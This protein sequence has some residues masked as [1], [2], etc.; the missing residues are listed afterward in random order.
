[1]KILVPIAASAALIFSAPAAAQLKCISLPHA[2]QANEGAD[3]GAKFS[4]ALRQTKACADLQAYELASTTA[5][6]PEEISASVVDRC[7]PHVR[8]QSEY[9][10][11]AELG[12]TYHEVEKAQLKAVGEKA[13]EVVRAVRSGTCP[14]SMVPSRTAS[15]R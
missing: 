8:E 3:P 11:L 2:A 10:V 15:A 9:A 6:P 5:A 7:K 1:M 12:W 14:V 13:L 4:K